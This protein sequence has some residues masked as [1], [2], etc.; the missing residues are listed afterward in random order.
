MTGTVRNAGVSLEADALVIGGGMAGGPQRSRK[1][2][3]LCSR[4]LTQRVRTFNGQ[5][6]CAGTS[7]H[8]FRQLFLC[9]IAG[10]HSS[11]PTWVPHDMASGGGQ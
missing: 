8:A 7:G 2:T 4:K 6:A 11:V 10:D 1:R 5:L 9:S 3:H